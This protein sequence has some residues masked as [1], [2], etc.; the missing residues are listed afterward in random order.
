MAGMERIEDALGQERRPQRFLASPLLLGALAGLALCALGY[1]AFNLLSPH[2]KTP[3]DPRATASAI[4]ADIS[5]Q[6]YDHLFTLLD[7]DLQSRG[8]QADF[9]ASQR[10]IDTLLGPVTACAPGA[11]AISG[12]SGSTA[13]FT[14]SLTRASG[15]L[16][17]PVVTLIM[18]GPTWRIRDYPGTI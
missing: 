13:T 9:V 2:P 12:S 10:Q 11:P 6:H 17:D 5:G 18:Q 4:C 8:T 1:L 14:F 3:P 7:T 15:K 16:Q